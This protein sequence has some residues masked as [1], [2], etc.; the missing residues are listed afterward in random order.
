MIKSDLKIVFEGK[1]MEAELIKNILE[2]N[3]IDS[4]LKD[5]LMGQ[6]FPFFVTYGGVK[7][8]KVFVDKKDYDKAIL[9]VNNY[10]SEPPA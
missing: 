6:L 9:I 4:L 2:A 5:A 8:V 1:V 3:D 7:P 10:F